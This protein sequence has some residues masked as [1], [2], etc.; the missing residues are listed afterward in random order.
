[1]PDAPTTHVK[2]LLQHGSKAQGRCA[3]S[4]IANRLEIAKDILLDKKLRPIGHFVKETS[5]ESH[6]S[7]EILEKRHR[8]LRQVRH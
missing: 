6:L 8:R 4:Y 1:M 7:P 3:L 2:R 5:K